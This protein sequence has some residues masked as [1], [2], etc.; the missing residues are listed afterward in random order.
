MSNRISG[1]LI[2]YFFILTYQ[3]DLSNYEWH[4]NL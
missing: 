4:Y 1:N 3:N 2:S